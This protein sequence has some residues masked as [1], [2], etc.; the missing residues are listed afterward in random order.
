MANNIADEKTGA[1]IAEPT[2]MASTHSSL[3]D[4]EKNVGTVSS[5]SPPSPPFTS[6]YDWPLARKIA[7]ALIVSLGQ[8]V[9]LMSASMM[10]AALPTIGRD[11]HMGATEIQISFSIYLLGLAFGPFLIG[12]ASEMFGRKSVWIVCNLWYI[13]WNAIC[14]V[15]KSSA[16]MVVGRLLAGAGA[17]CGTTVSTDCAGGLEMLADHVSS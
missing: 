6:P 4:E 3:P 17:S 8:L 10:A 13:F 14:P 15:G 5:T 2:I 12:P 16:V 1:V 11:L 9:T 7:I